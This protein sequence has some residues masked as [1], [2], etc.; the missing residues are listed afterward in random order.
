MASA[1]E[2]KNLLDNELKLEKL[3]DN[4]EDIN[5][6]AIRFFQKLFVEQLNFELRG[7]QFGEIGEDIPID[8]WNKAAEAQSA[9]LIAEMEEFRIIYITLKKI[10]RYKERFA[11]SSLNRGK[12]TKKGEYICIFFAENS[13]VWDIVCPHFNEGRM[14]LRRFILGDG[15]NHRTISSNLSSMDASLTEPLFDRVQ[16]AF[17]VQ[18]VI[19]E[20]AD[21]NSPLVHLVKDGENLWKIARLYKVEMNEIR[22]VNHLEN[23]RIFPGTEIIIPKS[24]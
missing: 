17:K 12:W 11:I 1:S 6:N 10:S 2:I 4:F 21:S 7:G 19:K 14:I 18:V 13:A 23:D 16:D 3:G 24:H 22:R 9:F 8:D 5:D 15:E 20:R